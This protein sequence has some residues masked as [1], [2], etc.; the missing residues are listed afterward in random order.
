MPIDTFVKESERVFKLASFL[1]D[2]D[3]I[4]KHFQGK[5]ANCF[6]A[7]EMSNRLN[8]NFFE[9]VNGLYVVHGSPGFTGAFTISLINRSGIFPGGLNF[10]MEGTGDQMKCT[11]SATKKDGTH[12]EATVSMAMARAEGWTKNKKYQTMPEQMLT[13]RSATFFCRRY[14]PEILMGARTIEELEDI[15]AS[16]EPQKV[17][18]TIDMIEA[19]E[20]SDDVLSRLEFAMQSVAS[21]GVKQGVIDDVYEKVDLKNESSVIEATKFLL[22]IAA[23]EGENAEC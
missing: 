5:K 22:E 13:Y 19:K 17:E 6:L 9:L 14:C 16:K 11:C 8:V 20:P 3:I 23:Q 12:C 1:S 2:S 18:Y 15:K 21:S 4:P 7:L 10:K